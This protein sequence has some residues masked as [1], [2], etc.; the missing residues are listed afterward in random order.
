MAIVKND[1]SFCSLPSAISTFHP[2][3]SPLFIASGSR[4]EGRRTRRAGDRNHHCR[5]RHGRDRLDDAVAA[6]FAANLQ[7]E[8]RSWFDRRSAR[9]RRDKFRPRQL[10]T[11][12][13]PGKTKSATAETIYGDGRGGKKQR[14]RR[15]SKERKFSF[16]NDDIE[17]QRL[18][19]EER[20]KAIKG[21]FS[22]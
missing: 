20:E 5:R 12:L 9:R 7:E 4:G 14:G 6:A 16:S 1:Y 18:Q 21:E 13:R 15:K 10:L 3:P 2:R 22:Q 17:H 19:E 8:Q 11:Y